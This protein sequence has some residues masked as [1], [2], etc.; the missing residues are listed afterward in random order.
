MDLHLKED[1]RNSNIN[2]NFIL[3]IDKKLNNI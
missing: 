3:N 2:I 1:I